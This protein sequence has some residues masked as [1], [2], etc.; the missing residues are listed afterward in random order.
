MQHL[1]IPRQQSQDASVIASARRVLKIE[2]ESIAALAER[3]DERFIRVVNLL[4]Q[5][6]G[7]VVVTGMGKS[8]LIGKKIAATFSSIG[9]P[10]LYLHAAEGSHGDVG[11][12]SRG[13]VVIA[14]SNSGETEEILKILPY[15][16]RINATLV[17]LTGNPGSTLAKRSAYVLDVSVRE[18][19]CSIGL[20]P[21]ASIAAALAMGD[22]LALAILD[23]R[24]FREEDF[25]QYHPGGSLGRKLLTT[26]NDLMHVG[27]HIPRVSEDAPIYEAIT[28]MSC[29]RLGTAIVTDKRG[30][31]RGIITDGDLRRLF[32][33]KKDISATQAAE[34]M[35][36]TPRTVKQNDLAAMALHIME[37]CAITCLVVSRDGK[38]I[39]GIIHLHDLL[40][41][42][43]V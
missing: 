39:D 26:V 17:S 7:R 16:T 27:E 22:A 5:C 1:K 33:A 20:V 30:L 10:A 6:P 28:E 13:D 42:G 24:G 21:T 36:S 31:L 35:T 37:E 8:G 43:I 18:E 41:A 32:E 12:V 4:D 11:I 29:K 3:L 40:K 25:A 2:S 23:K 19:A 9:I 14:I 34:I 15:L 38:R